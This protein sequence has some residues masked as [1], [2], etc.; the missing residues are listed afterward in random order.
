MLR[1]TERPGGY[2]AVLLRNA[3][4]DAE[5]RRGREERAWFNAPA[6]E[7]T[8]PDP[9]DRIALNALVKALRPQDQQL[10]RLRYMDDLTVPEIARRT[11]LSES[12]V[13]VRLVRL[14]ALLRRRNQ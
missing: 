9:V 7:R 3:I 2:L 4:R 10:L 5:R 13:S 12:A 14:I 11:G 8:Q 6:G 1:S